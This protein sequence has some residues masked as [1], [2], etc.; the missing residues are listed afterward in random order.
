M[1]NLINAIMIL[2]N[3]FLSV[4]SAFAQSGENAASGTPLNVVMFKWFAG[5]IVVVGLIRVIKRSMD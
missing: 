1:K 5:A 2:F 4:S 3:S